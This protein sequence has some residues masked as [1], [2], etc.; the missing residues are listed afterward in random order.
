[1]AMLGVDVG[2]GRLP[3]TTL[4]AEQTNT[5]RAELEQLGFFEWAK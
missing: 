4:T 5:L 1:M 2:P 3:N